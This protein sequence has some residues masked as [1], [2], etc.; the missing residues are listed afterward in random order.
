MGHGL[1]LRLRLVLGTHEHTN[2]ECRT[3]ESAFFYIHS[4]ATCVLVPGCIDAR[5][6]IPCCFFRCPWCLV[7]GLR[8]DRGGEGVA[9][10]FEGFVKT[11][12][13]GEPWVDPTP[14][15]SSHCYTRGC[16]V[17]GTGRTLC[18]SPLVHGPPPSNGRHS[19]RFYLLHFPDL[20]AICR[21]HGAIC[22]RRVYGDNDGFQPIYYLLYF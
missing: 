19:R 14:R 6:L 10:L 22:G 7:S 16:F 21:T 12:G 3:D 9:P 4:V 8:V 18:V 1:R 5:R 11:A 20:I 17:W 13:V 2:T 15:S